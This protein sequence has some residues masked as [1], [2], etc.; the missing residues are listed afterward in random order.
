MRRLLGALP[1]VPFG[2]RLATLLVVLALAAIVDRA[3]H[4]AAARR[5]REY[6]F[7]LAC[8]L[9]GALV[10]G[11]QDQL[12]VRVSP[13]YFLYGKGLE[14]GADLAWRASVLGGQAGFVAGVIA[15]G[16][17][18][19]VN[20]PRPARPALSELA[21]A[22][23]AVPWVVGAALGGEALG[24]LV[25]GPL[26][27]LCYA[28]ELRG[29]L[30]PEAALGFTRVWGMHAGLYGGAALGLVVAALRL[31]ARRA[32]TTTPAPEGAGAGEV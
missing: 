24:A 28:R 3:R 20:Q 11:L 15:A 5:W 10:G 9:L 7:L 6:S 32:Y 22:R 29:L 8:G 27:P 26:D 14:G 30:A 12:S 23:V 19:L 16:V 2:A 1:E 25:L 21:A 13:D 18:L 31:R 4:G 17:L